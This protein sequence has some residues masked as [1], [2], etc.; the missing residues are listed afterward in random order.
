MGLKSSI[1]DLPVKGIDKVYTHITF[2]SPTETFHQGKMFDLVL[3]A[4]PHKY[5]N[6]VYK[7]FILLGLY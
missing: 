7:Y 6:V 5:S 1:C 3:F 4:D 2:T